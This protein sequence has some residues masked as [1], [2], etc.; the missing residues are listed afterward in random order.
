M[1]FLGILLPSLIL[2]VLLCLD[3]SLLFILD[4]S[5]LVSLDFTFLLLLDFSLLLSLDLLTVKQNLGKKRT[6]LGLYSTISMRG[7]GAND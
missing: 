6:V 2:N 4:L 3:F 1:E 5:I 7:D